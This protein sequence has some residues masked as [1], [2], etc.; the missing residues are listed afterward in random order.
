MRIA[1]L[2]LES[3]DELDVRGVSI[4]EPMSAAFRADVG[5]RSRD[6]ALDFTRIVGKRASLRLHDDHGERAWTGVCA[7]IAQT[8]VEPRGLSTYRV[9]VVPRLWLLTQRRGHRLFQ[10][11]SAPEVVAKILA[12]WHLSPALELAQSYPRLPAV[13]QY[14]ESDYDF[15]RRLLAEAGISFFFRDAPGEET[16]LVITDAPQA[17]G[18][19]VLGVPFPAGVSHVHVAHRVVPARVT[20]TD[21]DFRRP[22]HALTA[23]HAHGHGSALLESHH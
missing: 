9:R 11:L 2:S 8:G 7:E 17:R 3:G 18:P 10:H 20:F 16:R 14:G 21:H 1:E 19:E 12:E 5:A 22:L 15:V 4:V 23:T 6:D 13:T